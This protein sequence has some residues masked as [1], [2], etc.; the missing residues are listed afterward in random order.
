MLPRVF[1]LS[2]IVLTADNVNI[3]KQKLLILQLPFV[4]HV[5]RRS[6]LSDTQIQRKALDMSFTYA[7][8]SQ[9]IQDMPG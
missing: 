7:A 4:V 2:R 6:R 3:I 1:C 8:S 5:I 9:T